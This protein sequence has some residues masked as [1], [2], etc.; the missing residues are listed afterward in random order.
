MNKFIVV[1]LNMFSANSRVT[2]YDE[3]GVYE[4]GKF[5]IENLPDVVTELAHNSDTYNVKIAGDSKF[6]QLVEFGIQQKEMT[7]YSER[8]IEIEVI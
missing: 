7:K 6:S 5:S 1:N 8:K 4:Q 3:C 2:L